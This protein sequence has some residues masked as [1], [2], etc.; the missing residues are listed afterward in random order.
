MIKASITAAFFALADAQVCEDNFSWSMLQNSCV[1]DQAP[2]CPI[3]ELWNW[4][5]NQCVQ[6]CEGDEVWNADEARCIGAIM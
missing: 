4:D 2:G 1:R 6:T 5:V 3:G